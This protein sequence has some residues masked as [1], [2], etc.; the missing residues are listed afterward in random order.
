MGEIVSDAGC[1]WFESNRVHQK[2]NRQYGGF[3]FG[4]FGRSKRRILV[5]SREERETLS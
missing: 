4:V 5:G 1:R 3:L 2:E